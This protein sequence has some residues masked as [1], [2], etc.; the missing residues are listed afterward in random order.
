MTEELLFTKTVDKSALYQGITIPVTHQDALCR[1][2]HFPLKRGEQKNIQVEVC[3]YV[4][5]DADLINQ[6]F[7]EDKYPN[8]SDIIQIRYPSQ[9]LLAKK[10]RKIF[11][12][13]DVLFR[14]YPENQ[15]DNKKLFVVP[16]H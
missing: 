6:S 11:A 15:R 9:S 10:I 2:M 14:A 8:H 5:N 3:G 7:D 12:E 4:F 13:T 16:E 1:K